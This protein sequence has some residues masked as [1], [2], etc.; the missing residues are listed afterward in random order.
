MRKQKT[1]FAASGALA[2]LAIISGGLL[3]IAYGFEPP[4]WIC[5][6]EVAAFSGLALICGFTAA[7]TALLP[8][9]TL[10]PVQGAL[11]VCLGVA[12]IFVPANFVVSAVFLAL[13]IKLVW[14][15]ACE[16]ADAERA[17]A[18]E[19]EPAMIRRGGGV[20]AAPGRRQPA[21]EIRQR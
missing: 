19:A 17:A 4:A 13:G 5:C 7:G 12:A 10:R 20:P 21:A 3:V 1:I 9:L 8:W 2:I 6:A 15:T 14:R 18:V 16:L 11:L